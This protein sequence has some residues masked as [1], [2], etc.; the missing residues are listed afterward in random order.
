MADPNNQ[1]PVSWA[2]LLKQ[3]GAAQGGAGFGG[4]STG[5]SNESGAG[6]G[7]SRR[8]SRGGRPGGGE[9]S[10]FRDAL[11]QMS[12][13]ALIIIAVL[14]VLVLAFCYWWFHPPINIH[15]VDL[16]FVLAIFILLPSFLIFFSFK[17]I[18][19]NGMGKSENS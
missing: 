14:V 11:S 2:D 8:G 16:W 9:F 19:A 7:G 15:S 17:Q 4:A 3:F 6:A 12:K 1:G 13:K 18:Y 10:A 5:S